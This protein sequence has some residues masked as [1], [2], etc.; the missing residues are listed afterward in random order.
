MRISGIGFMLISTTCFAFVNI[1]VKMLHHIPA[2]EL[3]FFRSIISF[4][5]SVVMI[6]QAKIP[7]LGNNRWWLLG[8]GFFGCSALFL[9][10]ITLKELPLAIATT[11]Q[12]LSPISTVL[13]AMVIMKEKVRSFQWLLFALAFSGVLIMK[14]FSDEVSWGFLGLGVLSATLSG[15]AYNCIMKCRET[16][17][18]ITIVMYFPMVAIPVMGALC[19][20]KWKTPELYDLWWILAMGIGTQISQIAMTKALHAEFSNRVMPIKYIGSIY[21]VLIG[22]FVF[23]EV[24]G[25]VS[26]AGIGVVLIGVILNSRLARRLPG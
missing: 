12:Y 25:W 5:I 1:C 16:D 3:V 24:L 21:A 7:F 20:W 22:Y 4:T 6:R 13:F 2:H 17:R 19:L 18:P 26:L 9:F 23:D 8:R 15:L 14:G 11:V 10:F